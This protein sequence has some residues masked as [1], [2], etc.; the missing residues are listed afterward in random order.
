MGTIITAN[1]QTPEPDVVAAASQ[2]LVDG[3][4]CVMPTDSVYG[5]G[6]AAFAHNPGHER[7]FV[8]KERERTQTLPLLIADPT[9]LFV[10]ASSL[11]Q[12]MMQLAQEFWPGALTLVVSGT[13]HISAEYLKADG[14]VAL[15]VPQSNL[16]RALAAHIDMPLAT[17]SANIHGAPAATSGAS[18]NQKLIEQ[19]DLI[20]NAGPAPLACASTIVGARDGRPAILREGAIATSDI[21]RVIAS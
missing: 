10:Y 14:S 17:T 11:P 19:A 7:I 4:V 13:S 16:V 20:I 5:I 3:G 9:D 6:C 18:V 15:R 8:I 12:W 1:Q 21:M 2:V